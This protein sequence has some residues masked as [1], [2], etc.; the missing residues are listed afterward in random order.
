MAD[1]VR[2]A[3]KSKSQALVP[4]PEVSDEPKERSSRIKEETDAL[5]DEID[6]LLGTAAEAEQFVKSYQQ[7][8]GE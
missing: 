8:G 4:T 6:V 3:R 7:R 2:K 1:Q 5:L